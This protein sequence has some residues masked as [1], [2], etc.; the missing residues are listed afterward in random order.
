M[1][2]P[3]PSADPRFIDG[4][5]CYNSQR[6]F[7]CHEL[8]EAVWLETTGRD[9][10]CYKGLI[11]AA[12]AFHHWSQGNLGGAMSL[13]K[14]SRAYLTRYLPSYFGLDLEEFVRA[15]TELFGWLRHHPMR[16]DARLVPPLRW[17]PS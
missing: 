1:L 5:S 16:Y 17:Q 4:I 13:Y 3:P 12:V 14:S 8:L 6:F 7:K 10:D 9:R 11:Q 15:Y 2:A